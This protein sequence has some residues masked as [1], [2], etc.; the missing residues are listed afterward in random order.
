MSKVYQSVRGAVQGTLNRKKPDIMVSAL[1]KGNDGSLNEAMEELE[2]VFVDGIG[3]LKAVVSDD[4]AVVASEAQQA[5]QVIASLKA[6][7]AA[8][9]AKLGETEDTAHKKAVASQ[10]MEETLGIEIRDLQSLVK[11]K[12]E[13]LESR[14]SEVND[15]K[16][17]I[18][19]LVGQV[20]HLELAIQQ[21]KGEA[22]SEAQQAEQVIADLKVKIATLEAQLTQTEQR[23]GGTDWTIKGLDQRRDRQVI[24]LNAEL[25]PQTNGMK[26]MAAGVTSIVT[27]A[28]RE[29]V[30]QDAFDRMIAEFSEL[31]NVI[32]SIASLIVRDHVRTLGESMAEFPQKRLTE[33][34]DSLSGEIFDDKLKADFRERLLSF[35]ITTA[36]AS[37]AA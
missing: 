8:L 29:T 16:S 2:K 30:S 9:E 11:T 6:N 33:L 20:T 31:T 7:M 14:D 1:P 25:E 12:E 26:E 37:R 4:Q 35:V 22:A 10:K 24:D 21:A 5:E 34:L 17:K 3:R 28:A 32:G 23:V 27:E 36:S 19:V 18:D 15:L 13:A